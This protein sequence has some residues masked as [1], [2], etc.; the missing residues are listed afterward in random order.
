MEN[1]LKFKSFIKEDAELDK[2]LQTLEEAKAK[3]TKPAKPSGPPVEGKVSNNTA[4]VMHEL[5]TGYHLNGGKHM[6]KHRNEAG[7][8][9]QEAHDRLKATMHPNDYKKAVEKAKSASDDIR[10]HAERNGHKIHAVHWTSKA[11]DIHSSTGVHST[12]QQD[13]SDL[14]IHTHHHSDTKMKKPKYVGVS[15][16]VT[17]NSSKHVPSSSLGMDSS[18]PEAKKT[19]SEHQ[20]AILTKHPALKKITN[21]EQRKEWLRSNPKAEA[22]IKKRNQGTLSKVAAD[23]HHHLTTGSHE[24]LVHHIRKVLHAHTTPLQDLGHDHIKHVTYGKTTTKHH[25]VNPGHDY[26]HILQHPEHIEVR[27]SGGTLSFHDKRTGKAFARHSMKFD[28]QSDPL[29]SLKSA[30]TPAGD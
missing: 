29:S 21:P 10:A 20:K 2:I 19:Y 23:L 26:E 17:K 6:E 18:G 22:D 4:G 14:M 15:L 1:M 3:A 11:G 24:D 7:E 8:S 27:H 9:P 30:G 13:A 28:S 5:L 25:I 16:K 12:Q